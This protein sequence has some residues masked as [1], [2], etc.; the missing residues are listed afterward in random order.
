M[1]SHVMLHLAQL[2][3]PDGHVTANMAVL[4]WQFDETAVLPR[5]ISRQLN[6]FRCQKCMALR[7]SRCIIP[8]V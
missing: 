2:V 6:R 3:P 8:F 4:P 7:Q 1:P 5:S